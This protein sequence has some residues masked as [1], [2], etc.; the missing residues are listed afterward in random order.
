MHI[1]TGASAYA[2]IGVESDV[3]AASP[4]QLICLLFDG[5]GLAIRQAL[6]HLKA[7]HVARKGEAISRALDIINNGLLASLDLERG[8]E[9]GPKLAQIYDYIGRRLLY[10]NLH[11]DQAAL[12]EAARLL[13]EI[14]SAWRDIDPQAARHL[15]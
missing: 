12:L 14:G 2:N 5:A 3:M 6:A 1:R 9:M 7:G 4:Y 15:Q 8:G 10:G 11:N 13:E